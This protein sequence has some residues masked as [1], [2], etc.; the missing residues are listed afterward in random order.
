MK[1]PIASCLSLLL[2]LVLCLI[3]VAFSEREPDKD[4]SGDLLLPSNSSAD[5]KNDSLVTVVC[6]AESEPPPNGTNST[7]RYIIDRPS[8]DQFIRLYVYKTSK[9]LG[10][11]I[12][13]VRCAESLMEHLGLYLE[14]VTLWDQDWI[15]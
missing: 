13:I 5:A 12:V 3:S 8:T 15:E 2:L 6:A 10:F 7:H 9:D 14:E 4:A 1:H 11:V